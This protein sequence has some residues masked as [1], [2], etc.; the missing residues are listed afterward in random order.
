MALIRKSKVYMLLSIVV[1]VSIFGVLT[2]STFASEDATTEEEEKAPTFFRGFRNSWLDI[3]TDDQ[4]AQ[5]E[6]VIEENRAKVQNR[7]EGWGVQISE[8]DDQQ[9]EELK[10]IIKENRA[11]VKELLE[12]WNIDTPIWKGP[13]DWQSSLTDEQKEELQTMRQEYVDAVKAKLEEWGVETPEVNGGPPSGMGFSGRG[14]VGMRRQ[15][16]GFRDFGLFKP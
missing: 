3:L 15:R 13:M 10:A 7:L 4:L 9:R 11:E 5:L 8:L 2:F 14:F 6:Q 1:V 16:G 12:S